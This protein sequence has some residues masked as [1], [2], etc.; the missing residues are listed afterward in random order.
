MMLIKMGRADLFWDAGGSSVSP[1]PTGGRTVCGRIG[2]VGDGGIVSDGN[3]VVGSVV[4]DGTGEFEN[5]GKVVPNRSGGALRT[6]VSRDARSS[7][8]SISGNS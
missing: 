8:A 4:C 7:Y 1:G 3:I 6:G 2:A 5:N